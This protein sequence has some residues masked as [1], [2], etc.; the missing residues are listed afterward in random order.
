VSVLTGL[1][2][3]ELRDGLAAGQ[4]SARELAEA[5]NDAVVA[6]APLNA[7]ITPTPEHA[8]AMAGAVDAR[9]ARGEAR[10]LDGVPIAVKDLFCSKGILTTA[11]SHIL[12]SSA[13]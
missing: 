8:L 7:Y 13:L 6:A 2:I 1:T 4:F 9:R 5:Y 12:V 10:P 11:G 3:A